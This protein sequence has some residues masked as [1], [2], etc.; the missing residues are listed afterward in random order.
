MPV[1]ENFVIDLPDRTLHGTLFHPQ[2]TDEP[3]FPA[4]LICISPDRPE[5]EIDL[6]DELVLDLVSQEKAVV[7]Y[8]ARLDGTDATSKD[9]PWKLIV[10][11]AAA[12]FRWMALHDRIDLT[13]LGLIGYGQGAVTASCLARRTDQVAGLCLIAP[14]SDSA[15][16]PLGNGAETESRPSSESPHP[17]KDAA[18]FDRPTFILMAGA[19]RDVPNSD[20]ESYLQGLEYAEHQVR[21]LILAR[22]DHGFTAPSTRNMSIQCVLDFFNT[23]PALVTAESDL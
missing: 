20:S 19:D 8:H 2:E 11:D 5:T 7:T 10:D 23:M 13:R 17:I 3:S 1:Q 4:T 16:D 12:V 18:H 6:V 15:L 21:H 9:D 22:A 14:A